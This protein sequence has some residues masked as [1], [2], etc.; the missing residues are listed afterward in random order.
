MGRMALCLQGGPQRSARGQNQKW[1]PNHCHL[2]VPNAQR[3]DK[4]EVALR[5][6][7]L[8]DAQCGEEIKVAK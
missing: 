7:R 5:P 1:L 4:S 6:L 3:S 8:G 2:E